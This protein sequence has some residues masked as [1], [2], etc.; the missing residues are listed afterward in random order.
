MEPKDNDVASIM[1]KIDSTGLHAPV[2]ALTPFMMSEVKLEGFPFA[3]YL[4][5]DGIV[6]AKGVINKMDDIDL[7]VSQ[8]RRAAMRKRAS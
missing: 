3:Y 6:L 4:S 7:L 8:G 2:Y 5:A 1:E